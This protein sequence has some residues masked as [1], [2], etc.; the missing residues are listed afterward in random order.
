MPAQPLSDIL[1]LPANEALRGFMQR[2]HGVAPGAHELPAEL[3]LPRVLA[4]FYRAYGTAADAWLVNRLQAP[5]DL[6]EDEEDDA[7]L[8]FYVE[9]QAVYLWAIKKD[10]VGADDPPVWCR[11]NDPGRTWVQDAPTVSVFLL[12]MVV[13]S[14]ALSGPHAA[15]AAWLSREDAE[16]M[17]AGLSLLNL[18]PWHWPGHPARWYAGEDVVAFT[19]PNVAPDS[20]EDPE[21]SVWVS[22]LSEDGLRFLEPHISSAWDY[23]SPRD[24]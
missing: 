17:L 19:C 9:E 6:W 8:V 18:P 13:M 20:G 21:L 22:A 23:Y 10:D 12:Q 15:C 11:E 4:D 1:S 3:R 7:F 16:T 14:A 24:G 2:W 5:D